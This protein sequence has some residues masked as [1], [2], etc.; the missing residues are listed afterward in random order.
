MRAPLGHVIWP[1]PREMVRPS[2]HA[3]S[4]QPEAPLIDGGLV[5]RG[6]S[7]MSSKIEKH[8]DNRDVTRTVLVANRRP[9]SHHAL[10]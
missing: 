9:P 2:G 6:R 5:E 10:G 3:P 4:R 7:A 8:V 1:G